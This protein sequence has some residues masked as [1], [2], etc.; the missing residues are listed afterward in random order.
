MS[1]SQ[2][3]IV[4][5]AGGHA[6]VIIDT[7]RAD[8]AVDLAGCT[9]VAGS[10]CVGGVPVL[11]D[12]S[13]LPEL[14]AQGVHQAFVAIG[15][16]RIRRKMARIAVDIGYTLIN[17]ISQYAYISPSASLGS[18][19]AIMPGAVVNAEACIQDYAIINTGATVDHESVIG[20]ACHIAP[21]S[22][23]SGNVRIGEGSF[24]GTGTQVIDGITVGAWS[25][26]GAGA[27]VVRNIPDHCIAIGVP[28]RVITH[29]DR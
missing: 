11:G 21:G 19:I 23:L 4:I 25:V 10:G 16:N 12:D 7:L 17:A 6:K 22:H 27:V 1:D 26:L 3:T 18:G 20:E 28:A 15:D 14:Y 9:S 2:R 5:G 13:I 29:F 24:L 8:S